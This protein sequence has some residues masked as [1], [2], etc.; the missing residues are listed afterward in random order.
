MNKNMICAGVL[1]GG[2]SSRMGQN[3]AFLN[4]H[5]TSF[6]EYILSLTKG[7]GQTLLS[8]DDKKKYT[9]IDCGMVEDELKGFGPLEG[10]YGL[11]SA[12]EYDHVLIL[13]TD[14]PNMTRDFLEGIAERVN[15][16]HDAFIVRA[17]GKNQPLCSVYSKR[18]I[19]YI[20]DMRKNNT[21]RIGAL[22]EK[23]NVKY[24]SVEELGFDKSVVANIN[25]PKDYEAW[26]AK[27][28]I[29]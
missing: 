26:K 5:D 11:L 27:G 8:V 21:G 1:A 20:E 18:V 2:K 13:A 25:T 28:K 19:P 3:K 4:V 7:F 10:I 6:I 29:K 17:D 9:G 16:D 22:F 14:M 23:I 15:Y 24:L 12:S